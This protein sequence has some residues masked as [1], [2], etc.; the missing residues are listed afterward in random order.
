MTT[1]RFTISGNKNSLNLKIMHI[2]LNNMISSKLIWETFSLWL[3]PS[4]ESLQG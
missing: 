1:N 2:K 4:V 3:Q